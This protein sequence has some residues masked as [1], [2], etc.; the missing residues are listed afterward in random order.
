MYRKALIGVGLLWLATLVS[1]LA[2][3]YSTQLGRELTAELGKAQKTR[4]ELR[5]EQERLLLEKG[6]WSA[7]GRVEKV[8][9]EKLGMHVPAPAEQVLVPSE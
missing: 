5:Y 6:A 9:R 2:V 4:D 8:A 3:V 1:A 7:Y